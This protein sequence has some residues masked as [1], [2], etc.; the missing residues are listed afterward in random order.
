MIDGAW[1]SCSLL[2]HASPSWS[3]DTGVQIAT[4]FR[5]TDLYN[6]FQT[7]HKM[8]GVFLKGSKVGFLQDANF[9]RNRSALGSLDAA[10][11]EHDITIP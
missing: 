6:L 4:F 2:I 9:P 11:D 8:I 10:V 1:L 7:W 3:S 5:Q